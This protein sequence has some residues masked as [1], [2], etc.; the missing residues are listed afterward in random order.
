MPNI[1]GV[2]NRKAYRLWRQLG[3]HKRL[4]E[5]DEEGGHSSS[6]TRYAKQHASLLASACELGDQS[7]VVDATACCGSDTAAFTEV[8][9]RVL[10]IERDPDRYV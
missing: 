4:I 9:S 2:S 10:A 6:G 7:S 8:F 1:H 3:R 5:L